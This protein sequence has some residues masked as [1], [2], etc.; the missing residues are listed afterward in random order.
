MGTILS[1]TIVYLCTLS[2]HSSK[3]EWSALSSQIPNGFLLCLLAATH[4]QLGYATPLGCHIFASAPSN[5]FPTTRI[6]SGSGYPFLV[7]ET[8]PLALKS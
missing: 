5:P 6:P 8:W 4:P 1:I 7:I 3:C 2:R